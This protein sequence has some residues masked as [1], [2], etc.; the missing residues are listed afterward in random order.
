GEGCRTIEAA[1]AGRRVFGIAIVSEALAMRIDP[2]WTVWA[3]Q[4]LRAV[5]VLGCLAAL[6]MTLGR[7]RRQWIILPFVVVGLSATVI[8]I[9]DASF[10]GGVRSFDGVDDALLYDG[11]GRATH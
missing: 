11:E 1:D 2:P 8:A 3:R 4:F 9:D 6:V 7:L 10:L 5:L